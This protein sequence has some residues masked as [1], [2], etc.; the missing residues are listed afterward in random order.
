MKISK[1]REGTKWICSKCGNVIP[2]GEGVGI[3]QRPYCEYCAEI[4]YKKVKKIFGTFKG[5][6]IIK[7]N[8]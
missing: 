7:E 3:N 8:K 4:L 2:A 5:E 6:R 1:L